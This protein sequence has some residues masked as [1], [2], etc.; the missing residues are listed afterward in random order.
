[1][2]WR[3]VEEE[4]GEAERRRKRCR[5]IPDPPRPAK[6]AFRMFDER[7]RNGA[8]RVDAVTRVAARRFEVGAGRLL[9]F[10][11]DR[12]TDRPNPA[13]H[14]ISSIGASGR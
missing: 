3:I 4:R 1:M 11:G 13:Y 10:S 14:A 8:G 12:P 9:R 6:T 5:S 2:E 7:D